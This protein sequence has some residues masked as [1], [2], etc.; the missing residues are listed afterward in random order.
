M[1]QIS[2]FVGHSFTK[3][4]EEV[5]GKFLRH[6][7]RL[8]LILPNF[9][10]THAEPAE[11]KQLPEKVLSL[12]E[13][14][15]V[16]IGICTK[17]EWAIADTSLSVS[18]FPR[19]YLKARTESFVWKTSDWIIQEIGL[20]I[21]KGLSL[22][23]LVENGVRNPGGLQGAVEFIPFDR[24]A[25]EKSFDKII[26]MIGA[27]AE[28]TTSVPIASDGEK[29]SQVDSNKQP[30]LQNGW[31]SPQPD[32]SRTQYEFGL[33]DSLISEEPK[34][35]AEIDRAF[36][37][38]P[39]AREND[40]VI[41]WEAHK[42]YAQLS[43]GKNGNLSKLKGLAEQHPLI[44]KISE[45][46][47]NVYADYD[48]ELA[49]GEFEKASTKSSDLEEK[50]RLASRAALQ[51]ARAGVVTKTVQIAQE[52]R[53]QAAKGLVS[54]RYLLFLIRDLAELSK[55]DGAAISAM[56]R[57]VAISPDDTS[58]RFRLAYKHSNEGNSDMALYH[59]LKIPYLKRDGV[60]WNNLGVAYDGFAMRGKAVEAYRASERM[61][62]TLAM[63]NLA[64][65]F[66]SAGFISEAQAECDK[67]TSIK[68][69][70]KSILDNL[71]QLRD[72]AEEENKKQKE[73][74]QTRKPKIEFYKNIGLAV[75]KA[76]PESIAEYWNRSDCELRLSIAGGKV[77]LSGR[78]QRE[79]LSL[80]TLGGAFISSKPLVNCSV[81][82]SGTFEGRVIY[83]VVKTKDDEAA[84][85]A[86]TLLGAAMEVGS[87]TI[88]YLNDEGDKI[89]VMENYQSAAPKFYSLVRSGGICSFHFGA[90]Q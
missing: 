6:F 49:A 90:N 52:L 16:F 27:L 32:W 73:L 18:G 53:R 3:D 17:K 9:T 67:A 70:N 63:S 57:I 76:M 65:K 46:L 75:T 36:L 84:L 19:N 68:D 38:T 77:H 51:H 74:L 20:A 25:P 24:A 30:T 13:G 40:G 87:K 59:Y 12:I 72:Q 69:Y 54:E 71:A 80:A 48:N 31:L 61:G 23:L 47:A 1:N 5:V 4:D 45:Y 58:T 11:P 39:F 89:E 8:K 2:A 43:F 15:N 21:G 33:I 50:A 60:T 37:A 82:Y 26:E 7:D 34:R 86:Q 64:R 78:Y 10:W 42:E 85:A 55:D 83:A 41:I 62:E 28:T 66:I 14:K 29:S 56:E 35:F 88:M 81:D 44:S 79:R 22:I